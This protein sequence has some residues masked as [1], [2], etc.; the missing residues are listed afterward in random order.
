[1]GTPSQARDLYIETSPRF[2]KTRMD[3]FFHNSAAPAAPEKAPPPDHRENALTLAD[4][5]DPKPSFHLQNQVRAPSRSRIPLE[6]NEKGSVPALTRGHKNHPRRI[7][8][9]VNH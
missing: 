5:I 9:A 3:I 4:R 7:Y 1:M 2:Y 8:A 6:A